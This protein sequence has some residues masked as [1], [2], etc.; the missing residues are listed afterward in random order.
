[1]LLLLL[2]VMVMVKNGG[3]QFQSLVLRL[4]LH[5]VPSILEPD[6]D[7]LRTELEAAGQL[8]ALGRRQVALTFETLFQLEYLNV[9]FELSIKYT[10]R[11]A[12]SER[13]HAKRHF[14]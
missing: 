7:L 4:A 13:R 12:S 14:T 8:V 10:R 9:K 1:M 11:S 2:L 3:G 6:L 5:L